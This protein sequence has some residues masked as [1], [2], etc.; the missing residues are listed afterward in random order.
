M[1][2]KLQELLDAR[3]SES[4]NRILQNAEIMLKDYLSEDVHLTELAEKAKGQKTIK[5]I[6][7]ELQDQVH[8]NRD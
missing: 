8:K 3:S 5:I 7:D 6:L 4:Q 2:K 1:A